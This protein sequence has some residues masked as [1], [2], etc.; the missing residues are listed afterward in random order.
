MALVCILL[1]CPAIQAYD[2]PTGCQDNHG[3][4]LVAQCTGCNMTLQTF[5]GS[6]RRNIV[7]YFVPR[8]FQNPKRVPGLDHL[9]RMACK[10]QRLHFPLQ[11]WLVP[12]PRSLRATCLQLELLGE[13]IFPFVACDCATLLELLD[14]SDNAVSS[15]LFPL[16]HSSRGIVGQSLSKGH[17]LS[18][19]LARP[20]AGC[21]VSAKSAW[22]ITKNLLDP[23]FWVRTIP[24]KIAF[25]TIRRGGWSL[26]YNRHNLTYCSTGYNK[27]INNTSC[28]NWVKPRRQR[29]VPSS[30]KLL[31]TRRKLIHPLHARMQTHLRSIRE[32][33]TDCDSESLFSLKS[34]PLFFESVWIQHQ[35]HLNRQR[36]VQEWV[37]N[38]ASL[39]QIKPWWSM[40][41]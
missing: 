25:Y 14:L 20:L 16:S 34:E 27:L 28:H 1:L 5:F 29:I 26:Y 33:D 10:T 19:P 17:G 4:F 7:G 23:S 12:R 11:L 6:F 15:F 30:C 38:A 21:V 8:G 18:D 9:D 32:D 31:A 35:K 24:Q 22:C 2:M 40:Y 39:S 41:I 37:C 13:W 3:F 36:V